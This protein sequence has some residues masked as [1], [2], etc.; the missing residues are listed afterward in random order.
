MKQI[1]VN[2]ISVINSAS[3]ISEQIIDGDPHIVIKNVVPLVDDIVMNGGLYP[4]GEIKSSYRGLNDNPAPY[5]HPMVDNQYVS[6]H[7]IR[8]VN[9]Y[10]IGAWIENASHDGSRVLVDMKINRVIAERSNKGNELLSRIDAIINGES[11]DPIHVSTGLLLNSEEASGSSKGKDYTWIARNMEWDHL[12][13][14]PPGV[15]GAGTPEDGVGIFAANGAQIERMT[16]NL[17]ES[18]I[19][20]DSAN[21]LTLWKKAINFLTNRD[22]SFSDITEQLRRLVTPEVSDKWVYIVAVYDKYFGYELDGQ[23]YRQ[24]Y[25]IKDNVVELSGEREKAVLTTE[26]EPVRNSNEEDSMTNEEMTALLKTALEPVQTQ[27]SA[28]N[29]ELAVVKAQN[30]ELQKQLSANAEQEATAMR[31][32]IMAELKLPE[33]A[34]NALSGD[35][36]RE[37]YALTSKAAALKGGVQ[38]NSEGKNTIADMEAPE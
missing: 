23:V 15:P 26:L 8:A 32:A 1:Q 3:N 24:F 33:V 29:T 34:V 18:L 37:T 2:V 35:A 17:S 19:P 6:A 38:T 27:L 14:L 36:L 31:A 5:N 7:N 12:A 13:I 16:V 20:D 9:Q 30:T 22:L 21:H 25:T 4:A 11:T 28:V 10:H